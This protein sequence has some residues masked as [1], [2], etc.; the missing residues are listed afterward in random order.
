MTMTGTPDRDAS[1]SG[2]QLALAE[3]LKA[4]AL[5]LASIE[6]ALLTAR[7]HHSHE[8]EA[9]MQ[10][11]LRHLVTQ[12]ECEPLLPVEKKLI[13]WSIGLGISLLGILY[14][15]TNTFLPIGHY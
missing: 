12:M 10:E 3:E 15:V 13:G 9:E 7:L 1:P 8:M 4:R 2:E 5:R 6:R 14:W 11:L